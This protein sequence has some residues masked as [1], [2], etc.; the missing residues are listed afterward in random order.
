MKELKE[1]TDYEILPNLSSDSSTLHPLILCKL[2][3]EKYK[4]GIKDGKIIISNWIQH[5]IKCVEKKHP[6]TR[7]SDFFKAS[8]HKDTG[9]SL[10]AS[11]DTKSKPPSGFTLEETS[12][13]NPRVSQETP[14]QFT[15][16]KT[17]EQ[18]KHVPLALSTVSFMKDE[19][20]CCVSVTTTTAVTVEDEPL[21]CSPTTTTTITTSVVTTSC[22]VVATRDQVFRLPP[23]ETRR[24]ELICTPKIDWSRDTRRH[25]SLLKAGSDPN[26]L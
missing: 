19:S 21:Q 10:N 6:I 20:P 18:D 17:A 14:L 4:L 25:I 2:C 11:Q 9:V 15:T 23:P 8:K 24:G 5:V 16:N 13:A 12:L 26:Q 1:T 3:N 22:A 7:I